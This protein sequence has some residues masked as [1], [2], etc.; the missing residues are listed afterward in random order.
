MTRR[1]KKHTTKKVMKTVGRI[2]LMAGVTAAS[3]AAVRAVS[4]RKS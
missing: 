2:A 4:R 1:E 3:V